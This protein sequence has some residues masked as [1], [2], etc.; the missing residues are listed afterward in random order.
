LFW[1]TRLASNS[2]GGVNPGAGRAVYQ[3]TNVPI[4]D[5]H[6]ILN[7]LFGGGASPEPGLVSF[8]VRW[9]GVDDRVNI[10]NKSNGF[11]GEYVRGQAQMEWTATVGDFHYVSDPIETSSSE[12]AELGHER[13]GSFF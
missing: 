2:V 9:F 13:N 8:E 12:F 7:A 3:A 4:Q 10:K 5:F 1:T 11:A 6:S